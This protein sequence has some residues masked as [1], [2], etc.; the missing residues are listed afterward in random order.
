MDSVIADINPQLVAFHNTRYGTNH[1]VVD[2]D[3]YDLK[4]P[5]STDYEGV[6]KKVNE[7]Y[8]SEFLDN[9]IPVEGSIEGLSYLST[10]YEP[11]LITA[12]PP[13]IENKTRSWL[14]KYFPNVFK[15]AIHTNLITENKSISKSKSQVCKDFDIEIMIDDV[16][17]YA[18]D[19][20]RED[21]RVFLLEQPWNAKATKLHANITRLKSW[22]DVQKHL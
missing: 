17:T 22:K 9:T 14:N 10:K 5:W 6:L 21:I 8:D 19:C 20:A 1:T 12:R 15:H 7:F 16:L 3:G 4:E 2:Y 13:R 18:H 11:V